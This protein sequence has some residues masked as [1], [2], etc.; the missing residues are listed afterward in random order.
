[1][2]DEGLQATVLAVGM[3][4]DSRLLVHALDRSPDG[5]LIVDIDGVIHFA[6]ASVARMAGREP[7][8]FVGR[9]VDE[10]VPE[11]LRPAHREHRRSFA[12][13][14][15]QR[16]MGSGLELML[17]RRD[18]T[19]VPVEISLSPLEHDGER[20]VI[21][22]VRDVSD[23]ME[24][25]RRL[26]AANEQLTLVSE[27]ARIGRDLHDVVLQHLYGTG[28]S[29]QAVA[30]LAEGEL[31]E[32]LDATIDD[33]DRI[34]SEVRTIVFTLGTSGTASGS[35]D[36]SFGQELADVMAQA[37]R[38]LGFTPSL[39]LD[40]PVET[41]I[42]P[43]IR[44]EMVASMREALGNVA[45]HAKAARVEVLVELSGQHVTMRVS[46]DGV[47]PPPDLAAAYRG[48]HGLANLRSRAA[49]LGGSCALTAGS[50]RG[51][52]LVWTVPFA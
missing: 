52:V 4:I 41:A 35:G 21:A 31:A 8:E 20:Y 49:S 27:R 32:R 48:G 40:G 6:N 44:T 15:S 23:R 25:Q 3:A 29:V 42:T 14:P 1:M 33:I 24:S 39:R 28:L 47:G 13:N 46:D 30:A 16:A 26:A 43:E 51:S 36:G 45:R 9:S 10:L 37:S 5:V 11:S 50:R 12:E 18:R 17:L 22:A 34:I 19:L 2:C 38:V 7:E